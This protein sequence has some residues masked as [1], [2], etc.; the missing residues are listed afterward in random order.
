MD[1]FTDT[2]M[3]I[4]ALANNE[5][6]VSSDRK[7]NYGDPG[8]DDIE[9]DNELDDDINVY[10]SEQK[11]E[12]LDEHLSD[13]KPK[14]YE[15]KISVN[16]DYSDN[17]KE[18][19]AEDEENDL[20]AQ[21]LT[22]LRKIGELAKLNIPISQN[23]SIDSDLKTMKTEYE[24]HMD[25]RAKKESVNW[26][27]GSMVMIIKGIEMLTNK[28]ENPF[29]IKLGNDLST[30]I[31][32][33]A[34][35]YRLILGEI[36]EKYNVPGKSMPPEL[37]LI[38]KVAGCASMIGFHKVIQSKIPM[39][40][41]S[42]INASIDNEKMKI[43]EKEDIARAE[44]AKVCEKMDTVRTAR[45]IHADTMKMKNISQHQKERFEKN[46]IMT[47][48][49]GSRK[50]DTLQETKKLLSYN[51][52]LDKIGTTQ[53]RGSKSSVLDD[54]DSSDSSN[55]S[56]LESDT[57]SNTKP[58]Y[59]KSDNSSSNKKQKNK[60][61][62][63]KIPVKKTNETKPVIKQVKPDNKKQPSKSTESSDTSELSSTK[64]SRSAKSTS[65]E[66]MNPDIHNI[67]SRGHSSIKDIC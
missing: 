10:K 19:N 18:R 8:F 54:S 6:I 59:K 63:K 7:L 41:E 52:L 56:E 66:I 65:S 36:Y 25:I 45:K 16:S 38:F 61:D 64:S 53:S 60:Q 22:M 47:D 27:Y 37:K 3:L 17:N 26:M 5:K 57:E 23:Y 14:K 4:S 40:N 13:R 44:H 24:L 34:D 2:N 15:N 30:D 20:Y 42:N 46:L 58:V 12:K 28:F 48:T 29:G 31:N 50:H 21:K 39:F 43:I 33:N 35:E 49:A 51:K 1:N 67:L 9:Y 55:S 11:P 32:T 62:I